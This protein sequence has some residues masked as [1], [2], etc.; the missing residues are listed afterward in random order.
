MIVERKNVKDEEIEKRK[1]L[2]RL[3]RENEKLRNKMDENE[4][5]IIRL[6]RK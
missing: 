2:E 1:K 3:E 6:K 4:R 5:E